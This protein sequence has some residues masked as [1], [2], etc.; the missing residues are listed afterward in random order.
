MF[1]L[2]S[3]TQYFLRA[4]F[5]RGTGPIVLDDVYCG[6]NDELL[7]DCSHRGLFRHNCRHSRDV[8]V[9]CRIDFR[10]K[11]ISA[12]I[13]TST[14]MVFSVLITWELQNT[15]LH[16]PYQFEI[17][18]FN[19]QHKIA[20]SVSN[21]TFSMQLHGLLS[22][23]ATSYTCCVLALYRGDGP[24]RLCTKIQTSQNLMITS[25]Q[26][27]NV[28]TGSSTLSESLTTDSNIINFNSST[29]AKVLSNESACN[30]VGGVFG[31]IIA[32]LL[33]LLVICA[34]IIVCLLRPKC[35]KIVVPKR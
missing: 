26:P 16:E 18:C 2:L 6:S 4:H 14:G 23:M 9:R 22:S 10:L 11:N 13:M 21:K 28:F 20:M 34:I 19:E 15:T 24:K 35:L 27:S 32:I 30:T 17:E 8:G 33:L 29:A 5:G 31:F 25:I 12:T 7:L 3:D 1:D